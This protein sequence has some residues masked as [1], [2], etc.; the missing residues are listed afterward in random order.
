ME[1]KKM[2]P[3]KINVVY[4]LIWVSLIY[5]NRISVVKMLAVVIE[6]VDC[7]NIVHME[8]YEEKKFGFDADVRRRKIHSS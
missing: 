1:P 4:Y 3:Q 5:P 8:N 6:L 7:I 2:H